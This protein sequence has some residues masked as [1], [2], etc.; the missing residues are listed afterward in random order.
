MSLIRNQN[1]AAL[2]RN[3]VVLDLSDIAGQAEEIRRR[4]SADAEQIIVDARKLARKL[5]SSGNDMGYRDGLERGHAEGL[6][7]GLVEGRQQ[8]AAAMMESIES[9]LQAWGS[10]LGEFKNRREK[11]QQEARQDVLRLALDIG[12]RIVYRVVESEETIIG[13]QMADAL[14]MLA[15]QTAVVIEL[16]P[17]DVEVATEI[18]PRLVA[19]FDHCDDIKLVADATITRGGC[20]V[21]TGTGAIDARIETQI[22]RIMDTLLPAA[23]GVVTD[24]GSGIDPIT[25]A[26]PLQPD[27]SARAEAPIAAPPTHDGADGAGRAGEAEEPGASVVDSFLST[28]DEP[29]EPAP[30][31]D[32]DENE[33]DDDESKGAR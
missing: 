21:R 27:S 1:A 2:T 7:R 31:A 12:K 25:K 23:N 20:F 9:G 28:E 32:V 19:E 30:G 24:A 18:M 33:A 10:A 29:T 14:R 16:N 17:A 26:N 4:A 6:E 3:A 11:L 8:A 22:E 15:A 13:D 5:S